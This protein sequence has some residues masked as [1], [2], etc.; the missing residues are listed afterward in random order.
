MKYVLPANVTALVT[1]ATGF[2]GRRLV[3]KLL[4]QN[5]RVKAIARPSTRATALRALG[6]E[7]FE[8]QVYDPHT[9]RAACA[10]VDYVFHVAAAFRE[11]GVTGDVY[12]KVHVTSTQLLAEAVARQPG[13]RRFV[14]VS[15]MGVHGHVENPPGNEN[16]PYAPGDAY[17]ATK[18]EGELWIRDFAK[19]CGLSLTVIRPTGIYGPGDRR[20][21]KV[22]K[23]TR[24][25]VFPILGYGKCLYHLTHVEDLTN[26]FL[27]AATHPQAE[28]E[29]FLCGDP[30]AI[31][32]VDMMDIASEVSKR[33][34]RVVRIPATPFFWLA[35]LCEMVC[36][37]L[38]LAPPIYRR[39]VAFYTKDRSFDT[40][41]LRKT[42]G[43]EHSYNNRTGIVE[44][45]QWYQHHGW[46]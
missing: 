4:A 9:V 39:R 1:G 5:V 15:T 32:L 41:K 17:Q 16:S 45:V 22:F 21:L 18:L 25:P 3:E 24:Y 29:V 35:D 20:L 31:S 28:Q 38:K 37:P 8:G 27:L 42:L 46:L 19:R 14:H 10:N 34:P 26:C 12:T 44:T 30:E 13:F 33:H 43:F 23:F 7:V 40:S 6:C 2:T 36:K 11:A